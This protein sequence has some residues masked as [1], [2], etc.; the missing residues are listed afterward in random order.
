MTNVLGGGK[1]LTSAKEENIVKEIKSCADL[2]IDVVQIDA[3]WGE[4]EKPI[5][6]CVIAKDAYPPGFDNTMNLAKK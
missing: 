6:D 2:G 4:F 5:G 1:R 3:G